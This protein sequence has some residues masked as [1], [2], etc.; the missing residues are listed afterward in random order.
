MP[1]GAPLELHPSVGVTEEYTDNFEL[2]RDK[3]SNWRTSV[4]P[5]LTLLLRHGPTDGWLTYQPAGSHD[6]VSDEFNLFHSLAGAVRW[7][8]TPRLTFT[9]SETLTRSDEAARAD[10]LALRRER[11][12]FTSN[13]FSLQ[14]DH[15]V[16]NL[17]TRGYYRLSTFSDSERGDTISHAAGTSATATLYETNSGT[18]GYEYLD[19][20]TAEGQ[21]IRGHQLAVTL[22]RQLTSLATAGV[23]GSYQLRSA[24]GVGA[25]DFDSWNAAVFGGYGIPGL[26]ALSA[27]VGVSRLSDDGRDDRFTV[28]STTGFTYEFAR[29]KATLGLERGFSETFREGQNFGVVETQGVTASLTYPFP[30]ALLTR[31]FAEY[32][33][34]KTTGI[35]IDPGVGTRRRENAWTVGF[36]A[37]VR[38]LEWLEMVLA[39]SHRELDAPSPDGYTENRVRVS[40]GARF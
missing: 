10:R 36:D 4:S 29:A 35:G 20:S 3:R 16:R 23:S 7:L 39:A 21:D 8:A 1:T 34:N 6:T 32:R 38:L 25:R 40:L 11:R 30:P 15:V 31:L 24:S 27:S 9:L 22:A 19:S 12:T 28:S 37:S 18:V 17:G 2:R 33:E 13:A 14:G 5:G 26:W